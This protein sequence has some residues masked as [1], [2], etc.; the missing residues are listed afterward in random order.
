MESPTI[1]SADWL[2]GSQASTAERKYQWSVFPFPGTVA[3]SEV[4]T[5]SPGAAKLVVRLPGWPVTANPACP[6]ARYIVTASTD[7]ALTVKL[8]GSDRASAPGGIVNPCCFPPAKVTRWRVAV[9]TA[10]AP[11]VLLTGRATLAEVMGRSVWP[12]AL[13]KAR[14]MTGASWVM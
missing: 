2:E 5:C 6:S 8:S 10:L 3:R 14:R 1:A 13:L 12:K 4:E 9:C 11:A 7:C